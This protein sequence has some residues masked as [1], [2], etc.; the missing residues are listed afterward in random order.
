MNDNEQ[1]IY[2]INYLLNENLEY[3]NIQI[4][5]DIKEQKNLLRALFN[6]RAPK[7]VSDEFLNVQDAYLKAQIK[8][9][10]IVD[11]NSLTNTKLHNNIYLWKGDITN[12]KV[13]A[14]VNAANSA[15]LGCF[16]PCHSCIDNA[17]H[18]YAGVQ[19][20]LECNDI[21]QKQGHK[22]KTGTAKITKAYNLPCKYIIHTV[23]P[24]IN[25]DLTQNDINL[26]KKCYLSCLEIAEQ[27]KIKSIAFCCIS[28]GV[29]CFPKRKAAEIA[30]QT[31]LDFISENNSAINI[32]FN[33]FT[34]E[35]YNIYHEIL[36]K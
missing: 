32:V 27:N 5:T 24:I 3:K 34:N 7:P 29:F 20:R 15:M 33:V 1:R 10:T 4:P 16:E 13:D 17:I 22:E 12:L 23:G 8:K 18:T 2:L 9:R 11:Y 35:D 26:L 6:I 30:V 31:V 21:M 19:L 36:N 14:I 25:G 28:T